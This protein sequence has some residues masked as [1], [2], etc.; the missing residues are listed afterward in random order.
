MLLKEYMIQQEQESKFKKVFAFFLNED[1]IK[2]KLETFLADNKITK[3][4]F[5]SLVYDQLSSFCRGGL[6]NSKER[7]KVE[8]EQIIKGMQI[9][10][11]HS[12]NPLIAERISLDHLVEFSNYYDYLEV[13][14][15]LMTKK[16][17]ISK[18]E[19]LL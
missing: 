4:E 17:P 16:V 13:M 9:E 6:W 10:V 8:E 7:P 2:E 12:N 1:N 3:D 14:E 18:I 19:A 15:A 11:E 5:N